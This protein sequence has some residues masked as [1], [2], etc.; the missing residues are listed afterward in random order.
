VLLVS[1]KSIFDVLI[2]CNSVH[3]LLMN[4]VDAA[5]PALLIIE[6]KIF[7]DARGLFVG[8]SSQ[9]AT[10]KLGLRVPLYRT[11]CLGIPA[12]YRADSVPRGVLHAAVDLRRP[13]FG[14][15]VSVERTREP[16]WAK[17]KSQTSDFVAR[18]ISCALVEPMVK[19]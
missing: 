9:R 13:N 8:P 1:P 19:V 10:S 3:I 16:S 18:T 14:K 6:P 2:G 15:H 4:I 17:S 5:I 11:T 12:A 7:G